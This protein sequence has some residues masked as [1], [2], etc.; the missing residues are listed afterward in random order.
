VQTKAYE[1]RILEFTT[2]FEIAKGIDSKEFDRFMLAR[3]TLENNRFWQNYKNYMLT[4]TAFI[5]NM[6]TYRLARGMK[7]GR[8]EL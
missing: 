1:D 2:L 6:E 4:R 7:G 8:E 5:T 3:S